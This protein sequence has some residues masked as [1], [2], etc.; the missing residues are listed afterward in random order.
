MNQEV[1]EC[2][3]PKVPALS[4][5]LTMKWC[6]PKV[7]LGAFCLCYLGKVAETIMSIDQRCPSMYCAEAASVGC[8]D[9]G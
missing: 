3:V 6:G 8:I 7:F 4:S 1:P 5:H 2:S 9:L